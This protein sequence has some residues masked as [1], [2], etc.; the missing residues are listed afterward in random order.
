[1]TR[2][3]DLSLLPSL[4]AFAC[5]VL[6]S[7]CARESASAP[8]PPPPPAVGISEI[9]VRDVADIE[10]LPGRI[11]AVDEVEVRARVTGTVSAV[12]YREGAIVRRGDALFV[13]DQRPYAAALARARADR[14]RAK[15]RLDLATIEAKRSERLVAANAVAKAESDTTASLVAQATAELAAASAAVDL[16]QLDLE[17][18]TIRA[19]LAGR[20]GRATVSVGDFVA[21][22][23]GV[24]LTTI[25]SLDPVHVTFTTDE[26]TYLRFAARLRTGEAVPVR[27]GIASEAGFPHDGTVDFVA[28]QLDASTGTIT[29]RAVVA[30]ANEALTP[31]LYARVRLAGDT[32]PAIVVD[33]RAILTD[34]DRRYV[35]AVD[36]KGLAQRKDVALGRVLDGK[37]VVT[38]GLVVGDRVIVSGVAKVMPGTPVTP[39]PVKASSA[40]A[41]A[42]P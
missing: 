10:E 22:T 2:S 20:A 28:N 18:T 25:V 29:M 32:A 11:E 42:R 14:T 12:K 27:V 6:A 5:F 15:A 19:P 9:A 1:M 35:L 4:L 31:G 36:G 38:K 8:P 16:A 34:Q 3:I 40:A 39:E 7:A 24:P 33:E 17:F 13:I 26:A 37:R 30:N 41:G 21:A 23:A